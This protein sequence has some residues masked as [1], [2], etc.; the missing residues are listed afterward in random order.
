MQTLAPIAGLVIL[1]IALLTTLLFRR[2]LAPATGPRDLDEFRPF[3]PSFYEP[4]ARL[5]RE[6][7][8]K[9]LRSQPGYAPEMEHRLRRERR[10]AFRA[11]LRHLQHDFTRLHRAAR[12][13]VTHGATD[14]PDLAAAL[15]RQS[16]RFWSRMAW[17]VVSVEL[18]RLGFASETR[19]LLE[20]PRWIQEQIGAITSPA[21]A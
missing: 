3:N 2:L 21:A 8:I 7:D 14:R 6:D 16:V 15:V 18:A 10:A 19:E 13:L 9:F 1:L 11:Y 4:M 5:L 17:A 12:F 20:A